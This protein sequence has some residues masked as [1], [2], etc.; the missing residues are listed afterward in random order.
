MKVLSFIFLVL[1]QVSCGGSDKSSSEFVSV[2]VELK[3]LNNE[4]LSLTGADSFVMILDGCASGYTLTVTEAMTSVDLYKFDEGCVLK[5]I[6]LTVAGVNYNKLN[7]G[8]SDFTTWT[9]GDIALFTNSAGSQ[10]IG[11]TVDSQLDNPISG[12]EAVSYTFSQVLEGADETIA[13]S[14]V[15]D[16]HSVAVTGGAAP[17]VTIHGL[18]FSDI[19]SVGA[20]AFSFDLKC[21]ATI[22]A[23][24]CSGQDMTT[25]DFALVADTYSDT[26][27]ASELGALTYSDIGS[28]VVAAG[29]MGTEGGI[30]TAVIYGPN[31]IHNNPNMILAIKNGSS[32]K[33]F[34]LDVT[35]V[36]NP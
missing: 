26:L 25:W 33:Y 4:N 29:S 34:N 24:S 5:L 28:N 20:G 31:Q 6:S 19:N 21:D 16:S 11:L 8:A 27:S 9:A 10:S 18:A 35:T 23:N 36:T 13:D 7:S 2:P 12:T 3:V 1:L 14:V 15:T 22:S 17:P 30:T 32:Y